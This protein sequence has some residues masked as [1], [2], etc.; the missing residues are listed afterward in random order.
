[1]NLSGACLIKKNIFVQIYF[2]F[3]QTPV[4]TKFKINKEAIEMRKYEN[5]YNEKRCCKKSDYY[6]DDLQGK[7]RKSQLIQS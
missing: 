1:M 5:H 6:N 2:K 3:N 7:K 4:K